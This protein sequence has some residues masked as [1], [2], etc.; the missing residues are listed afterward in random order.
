[1]VKK[2]IFSDL[3]GTLLNKD[4]KITLFT[5]TI[6][7]KLRENNEYLFIVT[8]GR[9]TENAIKVAR[10]LGCHKQDDGYVIS[11][12]GSQIFSF[13]E[14]RLIY[15]KSLELD[16]LITINS[17]V[18]DKT[19]IDVHYYSYSS[20]FVYKKTDNSMFWAKLMDAEY[21]IINNV[22]DFTE[23][24][25][26]ENDQIVRVLLI[27][28]E[29]VLQDNVINFVKNL[30][31]QVPHLQIYKLF[32]NVYEVARKNTDKGYALRWLASKLNVKIDDTISFGDSY[33]DVSLIKGAGTGIVVKN[34]IP[35]L[36][37][38]ADIVIEGNQSNGPA[39]YIWRKF[40][41]KEFN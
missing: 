5:K 20:M 25:K 13:K 37:K 31:K 34:A 18:F 36:K 28:N 2:I 33:N 41:R 40:L 8:T 35:E 19:N 21:N 15:N 14:N 10:K 17:L 22:S 7:R 24:Q 39:L 9:I 1:M 11:N 38:I 29:N 23:K 3:D 6:M 30:A 12:N 26:H 32:N 27:F 4:H 16:D